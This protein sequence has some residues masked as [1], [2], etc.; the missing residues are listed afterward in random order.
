MPMK[1]IS[2]PLVS[3]IMPTYNRANFIVETIESIQN[4]TYTNWE[5]IIIDDGSDDNTGEMV[6]SLKEQRIQY[7][8]EPRCADG[9]KIKNLGMQ[10]ARGELF[11]FIDSDDIWAPTKLASQVEALQEYPQAGFCLTGGFNFRIPY[12]PMEFFY[13][14]RTGI[15]VGN[16]FNDYFTSE[17][18]GFTQALM[19]RKACLVKAGCFKETVTFGDSGF[20][21]EL[22]Y[23]FNAVILYEPLFYRRLH[24]NSYTGSTWE[25]SYYEGIEMIHSYINKKMVDASLANKSLF[26]LYINF[27]ED[28]LIRGEKGKAINQFLNA[29]KNKPLSFIPLRKTAKAIVQYFKTSN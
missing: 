22:A 6:S 20:I 3:I 2:C 26:N 25:K 10:R 1:I 24:H 15:K 5:L 4:Q 27:G 16:V 14:K 13:K 12:E 9:G 8:Y 23:H 19:L 28:C 7:H 18:P 29:W 11:A 21:V 17:L